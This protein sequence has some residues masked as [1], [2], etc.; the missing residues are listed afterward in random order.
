MPYGMRRTGRRAA[1]NHPAPQIVLLLSGLILLLLAACASPSDPEPA[2]LTPNAPSSPPTATPFQPSRDLLLSSASSPPLT[3]PTAIPAT[4]PSLPLNLTLEIN[5]LTGLP[6]ADPALLDRRPLAIKIS[7]YPRAIR[8]QQYGL[9]LADHVF[10]YYIEWGNTRFIGVFYGNNAAQVG[11][12]RSGRFFDEHV[13]RMYHAFLVFNYADPRELNYFG[14]TDLAPYVIMPS[15]CASGVCAPFFV[16]NIARL[17]DEKHLTSYFDMTRFP[18][19]LAKSGLEN[20]RQPLRYGFFSEI[21]PSVSERVRRVEITYSP[22]DYHYWEYDPDRRLYLRYQE[23]QDF[24]PATG[25]GR[26][27]A[28]LIDAATGEQVSAQNVVVLYVSH[29]FANTFNAKDEV[30]HIHLVDWG[31]AWVFRDGLVIAAEWSRPQ[32]DQPLMLTTLSGDPIYL[33]PG[34]TF[35]QVIG[36]TSTLDQKGDVW[37]FDFHTP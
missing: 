18:Q 11:P 17:P 16:Y 1:R 36:L 27:Y 6:A 8:T 28:P 19:F 32:R 4:Q 25:Q 13:A 20:T 21:P 35:F 2:D 26:T 7:N 9:N 29:T 22:T 3:F 23:T 10:E 24:D 34:R 33:R 37:S 14:R 31:R 30:Y 5:P 12:V 15:R